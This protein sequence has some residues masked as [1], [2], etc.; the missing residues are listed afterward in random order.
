M[1]KY[2]VHLVA[3][4][5]ASVE[6]EAEDGDQAVELAYEKAPSGAN[7]SNDFDMGDW[8]TASELWRDQK[9][10]DDYVLIEGDE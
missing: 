4:A 10:E 7:I 1:A 5:E 3:V 6:V 8:S 2:R 9:P